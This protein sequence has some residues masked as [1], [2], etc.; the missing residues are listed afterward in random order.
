VTGRDPR[1]L[2]CGWFSFRHGEATAGDVLAEQAVA[3]A[4][5]AAGI[6]HDTAW[7]PVFRPG[8]LTL[9][10]AAPG[11]YSHLV[12]TC[13]PVSGWQVAALHCRYARCRRIAVGVSVVDPADPAA[14][15]FDVML[16]RDGPG[17]R[18]EL[19]LAAAGA[20][21][22]PPGPQSSSSRPAPAVP[23]AGVAL[24]SG[25]GEY[26]QRRRHD[27][28]LGGLSRWLAQ[29]DCAPVLV[30]TR[31]DIRDWRLC[32][33]PAAVA[34]LL[35]RL[36]VVITSRLHGMVLALLAGVPA[37]VIDP[38]DGGGKVSSQAAAWCWPA[39]LTAAQAGDSRRLDTC[40]SW[41]LSAAGRR[42]AAEA[43][44]RATARSSPLLA[45]LTETL[46]RDLSR[47]LVR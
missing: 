27:E 19:D 15:G 9:P 16:A 38:V 10:D 11:R 20:G 31:L 35:A 39:V 24:A 23:A 21:W 18:S 33:T 29:K 32:S 41:C 34:A 45:A 25:Q 47:G 1:V 14:T 30:D 37:L 46:E 28:V 7:S 42:A 12:F 22:R 43:A 5:A 4:L 2:V 3:A 8:Q 26:G 44:A 13:G 40:W 36:D 6:P 17:L